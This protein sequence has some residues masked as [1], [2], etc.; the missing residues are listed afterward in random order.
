MDGRRDITERLLKTVLNTMQLISHWDRVE[1]GKTL[2]WGENKI[3]GNFESLF[4]AV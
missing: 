3:R 2:S 1:E 4:F